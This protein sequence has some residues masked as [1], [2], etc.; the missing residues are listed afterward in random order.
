MSNSV[1]K[2]P[3]T[4]DCLPLLETWLTSCCA[5]HKKCERSS[6]PPSRLIFVGDGQLRLQLD[7]SQIGCTR[8]ATL[9][10]C[11]GKTNFEVLTSRNIQ[12]FTRQ[13][14]T[15]ALSR[16]F[17]DAIFVA[18]ELK[19]NWVW[20]DSLCI[21]QNDATDWEV[22]SS[23]MASI[24]GG[25][26]LNIA[27]SSAIDGHGG[28]FFDR[29]THWQ[30]QIELQLGGKT[31]GYSCI[32]DHAHEVLVQQSILASRAWT[33]QERLLP[34]RTV[35][36]TK[37][38]VFWEC[39][40]GR[41]CELFP[42]KSPYNM[43]MWHELETPRVRRL[44]WEHIIENYSRTKLT[45]PTD[46]LVAI[47]GLV[48]AIQLQTRDEYVAGLWRS[49]LLCDLCWRISG[50]S[51]KIP[52]APIPYRSPSWSWASLD[53]EV[54]FLIRT[55]HNQATRL[56]KILSVSITPSSGDILGAIKDATLC[57]SSGFLIRVALN[58][59]KK[60]GKSSDWRMIAG[61]AEKGLLSGLSDVYIDRCDQQLSHVWFVALC[62]W[63]SWI[64]GLV[65][66]SISDTRGRYRRV[67]LFSYLDKDFTRI[68]ATFNSEVCLPQKNDCLSISSLGNGKKEYAIELV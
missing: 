67:G 10:H 20:I 31:A 37:N 35:F 64:Y 34:A 33:L 43:H 39:Q 9:S 58:E 56:A 16:T 30:C 57:I 23:K 27:A 3:R 5:M 6:E 25:A 29:E 19:I 55:N 47:S 2:S 7:T 50:V 46:K 32:A 61:E 42:T 26:T 40:Q 8:Y 52:L 54:A 38:Q 15:S 18:R 65:L 62:Q 53:N 36:F 21:I 60:D 68:K 14:P 17:Q 22:E 49:T 4:S 11:W 41:A 66:E 63:G 48:R 45:N 24:Y 12:N 59:I 1:W 28:L 51:S 44:D 13:I